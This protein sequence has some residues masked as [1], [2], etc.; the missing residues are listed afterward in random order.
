VGWALAAAIPAETLAVAERLAA[1]PDMS[2]TIEWS[3]APG[4]DGVK[5]GNGS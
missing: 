2:S 3:L 5:G 1:L 4:E